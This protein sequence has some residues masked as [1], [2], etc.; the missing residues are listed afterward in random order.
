[1]INWLDI[2]LAVLLVGAIVMGFIK[3]L[4]R[5]LIGLVVVILGIVLA[6]RWYPP[7]AK[8]FSS[9]INNAPAAK[10]LGFI[11]VFMGIFLVGAVASGLVSKVLKGGLS[12]TNHLL[13]GLIGFF[14]GM[15]VCGALV[16]ALLA[17]P[18][19]RDAVAY[20]KLAP[21]CYET[22]KA[23]VALIP[24]ELKDQIKAAYDGILQGVGVKSGDKKDGQKI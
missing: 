18:I 14:E 21:V 7:V 12:F 15:L 9:I 5:E 2:I 16:F 10:F 23:A 20:S 11:V 22:T 6:A 17:F 8:F 13:G 4:I 24:Q 19:N 3:G 1:M